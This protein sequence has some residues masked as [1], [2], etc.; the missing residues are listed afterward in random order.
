MLESSENDFKRTQEFLS[1]HDL[2]LWSRNM[3][4]CVKSVIFCP[5]A[6]FST[7]PVGQNNVQERCHHCCLGDQWGQQWIRWQGTEWLELIITT[8]SF[9]FRQIALDSLL[10]SHMII[11]WPCLLASQLEYC[12]IEWI[13]WS[14]LGAWHHPTS[15]VI[16]FAKICSC[17]TRIIVTNQQ[18][19]SSY[20]KLIVMCATWVGVNGEDICKDG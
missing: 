10:E 5:V 1:H 16:I 15:K 13:Y 11:P 8:T 4:T 2:S 7:W 14:A 19:S 17:F 6:E 9:T 3:L 12:N 20:L 18:V